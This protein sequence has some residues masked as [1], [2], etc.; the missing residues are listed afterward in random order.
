MCRP[1]EGD[2][3]ERAHDRGQQAHEP[4][5]N[6]EHRA[7]RDA[8]DR[9][10]DQQGDPEEQRHL[11]PDGVQHAGDEDPVAE[12]GHLE[13]SERSV[14][15][16]LVDIPH[17]LACIGALGL[18][19]LRIEQ[20]EDRGPTRA[21]PGDV[22][23]VGD[24]RRQLGTG[25]D[26]PGCERP[27][28]G[29]TDRSGFE[30]LRRQHRIEARSQGAHLRIAGPVGAHPVPERIDRRRL[31]RRQRLETVHREDVPA[32]PGVEDHLHHRRGICEPLADEPRGRSTTAAPAVR[33]PP[34]RA[35]GRD[36]VPRTGPRPPRRR[37]RAGR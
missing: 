22:E 23:V 20:E 19:E 33:G 25:G 32:R 18:R 35:G 4:D 30:P 34:D 9:Q 16:P 7:V 8:E 12:D 3:T 15:V 10:D 36:R 28:L 27:D 24:Q 37:W 1:D 5:G 21:A 2:E 6:V 29:I 14:A 26:G 31:C 17:P 13:A 11:G